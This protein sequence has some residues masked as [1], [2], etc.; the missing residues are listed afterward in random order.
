MTKTI[1]EILIDNSGSMGFMTGCGEEHENKY[2]IDGVTRMT[3]IKKILIEQIVPT[4][5]YA[6]KVIIRSFR[7][8][9]TKINE[10]I[11][12][13]PFI[14]LLYDGIFDLKIISSKINSLIDPPSGGTPITDAIKIAI[15]DLKKYPECDRKII[16]LTDGEENGGGNYIEAAKEVEQLLGI[17][18]K[19][20]I[21]GLAQD[22]SSK[23]KSISIATGGY[24]NIKSKSFSNNEMQKI[25]EPLKIAVLQD[26]IQKLKTENTIEKE[27]I[28]E[29][30]YSKIDST[31]ISI[32]EEYSEELRIKSES[33]LYNL[34][35][36]KH[37]KDYVKWLNINGESYSSHDFEIIDNNGHTINLIECKGT[38]NK[39]PTFYLTSKEWS[40][41]L[42]NKNI[43]QIY[44]IFNIDSEMTGFL[45]EN[46]LDSILNEKVVP[47]LLNPEI[48]KEERVF[49]TIT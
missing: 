17:K 9:S 21:I 42:A 25:I 40:H 15:S 3:L 5:E 45:I 47:Y 28:N 8:N 38:R 20:F 49:L 48:L 6:D 39:K 18:C 35:C 16:L 34:L 27:R 7:Y 32:D 44:R 1:I 2:L 30:K 31:T 19:I 26:T 14:P 41:F 36:E 12:N 37:G 13:E 24:F 4:I 11:K 29:L 22:E 23:S 10:K 46:L 43:Y 33:F